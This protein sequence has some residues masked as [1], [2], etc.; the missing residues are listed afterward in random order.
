MAGPS[1]TNR[2]QRAE[3]APLARQVSCMLLGARMVVS[4]IR[5]DERDRADR[6][7]RADHAESLNGSRNVIK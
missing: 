4:S 6:A 3:N 5:A 7:D 1:R 2:V